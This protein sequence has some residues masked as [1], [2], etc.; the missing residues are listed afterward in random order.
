MS[1]CTSN[2]DNPRIKQSFTP[3]LIKLAYSVH[4]ILRYQY[5]QCNINITEEKLINL[6]DGSCE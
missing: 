5:V 4:V 1:A 6:G 3:L 2:D